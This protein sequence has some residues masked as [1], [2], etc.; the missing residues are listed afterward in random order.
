MQVLKISN[1]AIVC[2]NKLTKALKILHFI[3][4]CV[5]VQSLLYCCICYLFYCAELN[6]NYICQ[7][8]GFSM[9]LRH[10][11]SGGCQIIQASAIVQ[12]TL[13]ERK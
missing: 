11:S 12:Y 13:L 5:I 4:K 8:S 10:L 3:S 7:G 6:L 9:Q 2:V 1:T